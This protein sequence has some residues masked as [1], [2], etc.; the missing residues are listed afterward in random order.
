LIVLPATRIGLLPMVVLSATK[1]TA[2]I[3]AA[4]VARMREEA[5]A[6]VATAHRAVLQ[7][8]TMP[9]HGVERQLILPNKQNNPIVLVPILAK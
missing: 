6:A 3:A 2:K 5:N 4:R 1:G 9:Q 7:I 8:R